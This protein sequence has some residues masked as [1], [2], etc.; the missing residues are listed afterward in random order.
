MWKHMAKVQQRFN[1][2]WGT[3]DQWTY[4]ADDAQKKIRKESLQSMVRQTG[5]Y[6]A[7][8]EE[9]LSALLEKV[10]E[11]HELLLSDWDI[12]NLIQESQ[13]GGGFK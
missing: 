4:N 7:M 12:E 13:K 3:R 8:R 10:N 9:R 1:A 2:V 5:R 6:Q 11:Q